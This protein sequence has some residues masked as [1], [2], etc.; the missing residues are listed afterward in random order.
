M[1]NFYKIFVFVLLIGQLSVAEQ[2]EKKAVGRPKM[3]GPKLP[4]KVPGKVGRPAKNKGFILVNQS[5]DKNFSLDKQNNVSKIKRSTALITMNDVPTKT[6]L[7]KLSNRLRFIRGGIVGSL[8]GYAG[9]RAIDVLADPEQRKAITEKI[10]S[11]NIQKN[12]FTNELYKQE[13]GLEREEQPISNTDVPINTDVAMD[14]SIR[15]Q[16]TPVVKITEQFA[17]VVPVIEQ[18][19]P[20]VKITEQLA[21]VVPII[22][23][24]TSIMEATEQSV[25]NKPIHN[26][27][28]FIPRTFI[29]SAASNRF[30]T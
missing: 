21:P 7:S 13:V 22:E 30:F 12:F 4:P 9:A 20:V 2:T 16:P 28:D 27:D 5:N 11:N 17:S 24:P 10:S 3:I 8:I 19:A 18:P 26:E 29:K 15:E 1:K 25:S 23:Q 6:N 14:M